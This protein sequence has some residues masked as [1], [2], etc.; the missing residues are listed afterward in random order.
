MLE[1]V[2]PGERIGHLFKTGINNME[3]GTVAYI[4]G[5]DTNGYFIIKP[6][7]DATTAALAVYPFKKLY[8]AE[9]LADTCDAVNKVA[10]GSPVIV[11]KGGEYITDKFIATGLNSSTSTGVFYGAKQLGDTAAGYFVV[12]DTALYTDGGG[13]LVALWPSTAASYRGYLR[14]IDSTGTGCTISKYNKN[15]ML[16]KTWRTF[17]ADNRVHFRVIASDA[18]GGRVWTSVS[19]ASYL[20]RWR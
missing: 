13:K 1:V 14:L 11:F 18:F 16:V 3:Q 5:V 4:S 10:S 7:T 15:F 12:T 17:N 9:D 19:T 6:P 8:Y 20:T 2:I